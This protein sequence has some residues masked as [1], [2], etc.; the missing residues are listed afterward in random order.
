[1]LNGRSLREA[2]E[3]RNGFNELAKPSTLGG[4]R[5]MIL[6]PLG[7]VYLG[8]FSEGRD[9]FLGWLSYQELFGLCGIVVGVCAG[10]FVS[11]LEEDV[12][13]RL[14]PKLLGEAGCVL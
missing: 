1:V 8:S 2:T 4:L 3:L 5:Q 9:C 13:N 7:T 11:D 10:H 6:T 12:G 14:P